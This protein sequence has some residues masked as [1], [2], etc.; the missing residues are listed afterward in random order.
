M[1][2]LRQ[3]TLSDHQKNGESASE[4]PTITASAAALPNP[5]D[6][7]ALRLDQNFAASVGVRK[8]LTT[9][10][11]RKP[12]RQEFVRV[13]PG[14]EWRLATFALEDK[15]NRDTFL[16][17][18]SLWG[19]LTGE[20]YPVVLLLAINRQSD[21]FLWP[22]K[23][24]GVDGRSNSWNDSALAA[25]TLAETMWIRLV[26]NMSAGIYDVY[27]AAAENLAEPTWPELDFSE[28]LKLA[29]GKRFINSPDHVVL[30]SLRG[31]R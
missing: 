15:I 5:F 2:I 13:R 6:P 9:I 8:V 17:D 10:P 19:E 22:A 11:T 12:N 16:V 31:E 1:D 25:A 26:A 27:E 14:D 18:R 23:L 30:Q 7:A 28:I 24:P 29:F 3:A 21:V 20:I 4:R